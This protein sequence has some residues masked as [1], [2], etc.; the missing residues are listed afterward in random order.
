MG[1]LILQA[2]GTALGNTLLPGLGGAIGGLAGAA[3]GGALFQKKLPT[4]R[5]AQQPMSDL[6]IVGTEYGQPIVFLIGSHMIAGQIWWNTD[7]RVI[8]SVTRTTSGGGKGGAPK[9]TTESETITYEMDALIGFTDVMVADQALAIAGIARILDQGKLIF[10]I[11]EGAGIGTLEASANAETWDRLTVYDGSLTQMPDP[12]YETAIIAEGRRPAAYRGRSYAFIKGLKLGQSGAVRNLT[13]EVVGDGTFSDTT[14]ITPVILGTAADTDVYEGSDYTYM[15]ARGSGL[16]WSVHNE[17]EADESLRLINVRTGLVMQELTQAD[18]LFGGGPPTFT[19]INPFNPAGITSDGGA[20]MMNDGAT[21]IITKLGVDGSSGHI[22]TIQN[23]HGAGFAEDSDGNIWAQNSTT[24]VLCRIN[25]PSFTTTPSGPSV[26]PTIAVTPGAD[27][28]AKFARNPGGIV[29]YIIGISQDAPPKLIKAHSGGSFF[30]DYLGSAPIAGNTQVVVGDDDFIY[31]VVYPGGSISRIQKRESVDGDVVDFLD[32]DTSGSGGEPLEPHLYDSDGFLWVGGQTD[33]AAYRK[34]RASDMTLVATIENPDIGIGDGEG[35]RK[36]TAEPIEG[37]V[38]VDRAGFGGLGLIQSFSTVEKECVT[39][40]EAQSRLCLRSGYLASEFDVTALSSITRDVC[41]LPVSQVVG[42]RGP[43]ELLMD[44]YFYEMTV[45]DKAYFRP[46]GGAPV[47]S[48]PYA[49]LGAGSGGETSE[50]F[51]LQKANDIELPAQIMLTYFNIDNDYQPDTKPS[52]R[53]VSTLSG[54]VNALDMAIGLHPTEAKQV[55][56]AMIL[57]QT[58]AL[59]TVPISLLGDYARLEPTDVVLVTDKDGSVFRLRLVRKT[60]R[61]PLLNFDAVL[62]DASVLSSQGITTT[63]FESQTVVR[64]A[65]NTLMLLLDVPIL[66]DADNDS[67]FYAVIKGDGTPYPGGAI[68]DSDDDVTYEQRASIRESAVFGTCL[69]ALGAWTGPRVI[70]ELNTVRVNVGDGVLSS[71]TYAA[72]LANQ[73]V[74]AFAI[75][76][77]NDGYELFQAIT[78]TLVSPGVYD[79]SRLLRGSRGTEWA[80]ALGH[81]IGD[82]CVLL[83]SFGMRRLQL[84]NSQLGIERYYAG[85]TLG[86]PISS[87]GAQRFTGNAIG[88]K[89]FSPQGVQVTRDGSGNITFTVD[90]RSRLSVRTVGLLGISVPLAEEVEQYEIDIFASGSPDSLVRTIIGPHGTNI[91]TYSAADQI[92][93]FAS[94]QPSLLHKTY[95]ISQ[96]VGRGYPKEVIS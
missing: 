1:Q 33:V 68:F 57:D 5:N 19:T 36:V 18:A 13:W 78:A 55:A 6:R 24:D 22:L 47:A 21:N 32:I 81:N 51:V 4:I 9:Q 83:R 2:A 79:L 70:D 25:S 53:L 45:S 61:Y 20:L 75:G 72:V 65:V 94:V 15:G 74:N 54:T 42:M 41:D 71:S 11:T 38:A 59:T 93:D 86:R 62:D 43:T 50:P 56:D 48:I 73:S 67:G 66:Q 82:K 96:T 37:T 29:N 17:D 12:D 84:L 91:L 58:I 95:Q 85:V 80:A 89:P 76:N 10:N 40:E 23:L 60:D 28:V 87:G 69:T 30:T 52:D 26:T 77:V 3:I 63:D 27:K 44:N 16:V 35:Y 8:R 88:L 49:D 64:G 39:V 14:Q 92:I 34:I 31:C 90:R 46:R 7:R